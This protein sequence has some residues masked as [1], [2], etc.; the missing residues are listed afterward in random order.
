MKDF[1]QNLLTRFHAD[2]S[3]VGEAYTQDS[4]SYAA[5]KQGGRVLLLQGAL[6]LNV[7]PR[8]FPETFNSSNLRVGHFPLTAVKLDRVQ[9][10]EKVING[11]VPTPDGDLNFEGNAPMEYGGTY[12]KFHE[13]GANTQSR[14]SVAHLIARQTHDLIDPVALDW[15]LRGAETPY[16]GT[17]DLFGEYQLGTLKLSANIEISAFA[18][19]QIDQSSKVDGETA[20]IAIHTALG[21]DPSEVSIGIR[22]FD[23]GKV[24]QRSRING[25]KLDWTESEGIRIGRAEINCPAAAVIHT[26]A[27]YKGHAQHHAWISDPNTFQNPRRAAYQIIDS[28]GEIMK[29]IVSKAHGKGIEAR[30]FE[31]AVSWLVWTLGFAPALLGN[32]KRTSDASD[33]ILTAPSGHFAIVEVTTGLL[34]TENKLPNLHDRAQALRKTLDA[35]NNK[36]LKVLPVIVTSKTRE[37]IKPD[38]E[39]AE[40]LG[41][42]VIDLERLERLITR[43]LL[44]PNPDQLYAEG[45]E[46]AKS[47]QA[48][49]DGVGNGLA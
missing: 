46:N 10:L 41:I 14:I 44:P 17:A 4:F 8:K 38:L 27:S 48:R 21:L 6:F 9:F 3:P 24:V 25:S 33:I 16:D 28:D 5:L 20:K 13:Y 29:E 26:I 42:L 15:E 19:A 2:I 39:L 23:K 30:N 34:K 32:T 12:K 11:V 45:E 36:H 1:A 49:Y 7:L 47:A 40:K 22:V 37:E 18:V 31:A 43:S 35:S